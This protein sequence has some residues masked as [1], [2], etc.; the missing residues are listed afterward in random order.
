MKDE[1]ILFG[2]KIITNNKQT[3]PPIQSDQHNDTHAQI[4]MPVNEPVRGKL[5]Q[6]STSD[7]AKNK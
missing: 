3:A 2:K 4:K 5:Q 7:P 6:D 1:E